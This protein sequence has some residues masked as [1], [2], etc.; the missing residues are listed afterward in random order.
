MAIGFN[1]SGDIAKRTANLPTIQTFT[2]SAWVRIRDITPGAYAYF[3]GM[4]NAAASASAWSLVGY[5]IGNQ[6]QLSADAAT[7]NFSSGMSQDTWYYVYLQSTTTNDVKAGFVTAAG[8][9]FTTTTGA[10]TGFTP[11]ML[12]FGSD[13]WDEW[14]NCM[15]AYGRVW[16]DELSEAQILTERDSATAVVTTNLIADWPMSHNTDTAD[17]SGHSYS[18]TFGGSI[19]TETGP[20]LPSGSSTT[21]RKAHQYRMRR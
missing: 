11:A 1:G 4:E 17:I 12:S 9:S 13:S 20:T 10:N 8:S 14:V 3:M 21:P 7:N 2:I 6:L 15:I 5:E 16:A 18:L 19:T